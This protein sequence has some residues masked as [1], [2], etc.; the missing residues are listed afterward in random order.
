M[1]LLRTVKQRIENELV[2]VFVRNRGMG[3]IKHG[4]YKYVFLKK[5]T[6]LKKK[7]TPPASFH[8]KMA[9]LIVL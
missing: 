6:F 4:E 2:L 7:L 3:L 5:L 8:P 1:A 9:L